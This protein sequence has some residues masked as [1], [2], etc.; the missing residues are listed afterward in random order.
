M[1]VAILFKYIKAKQVN[2]PY[3]KGYNGNDRYKSYPEWCSSIVS[4]IVGFYKTKRCQEQ[5]K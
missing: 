2:K 4:Y 1:D 5:D 3:H